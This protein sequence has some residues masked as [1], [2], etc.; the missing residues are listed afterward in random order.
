MHC[1]P[2][3]QT[4]RLCLHQH[5]RICKSLHY[6]RNSVLLNNS[7]HSV[8]IICERIKCLDGRNFSLRRGA[9]LQKLEKRRNSPFLNNNVF[10]SLIISGKG[11]EFVGPFDTIGQ[12]THLNR[13]NGRPNPSNNGV[14]A[15]NWGKRKHDTATIAFENSEKPFHIPNRS[16]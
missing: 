10:V 7:A 2:R 8:R 15:R 3:H 16:V 12:L 11:S 9:F 6:Y 4:C 14:I 1:H 13:G 5:R